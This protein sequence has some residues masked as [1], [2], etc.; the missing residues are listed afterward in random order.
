MRVDKLTNKLMNKLMN[1]FNDTYKKMIDLETILRQTFISGDIIGQGATGTIG[2]VDIEGDTYVYKRAPFK[3]GA[4]NPEMEREILVMQMIELPNNE[5]IHTPI[6]IDSGDIE[7]EGIMY[8]FILMSL[9]KD[10]KT[11]KDLKVKDFMILLDDVFEQ[12]NRIQETGVTSHNDLHT[13]NVLAVVRRPGRKHDLT[14][15]RSILTGMKA[16]VIDFGRASIKSNGVR[17]TSPCTDLVS[18]IMGYTISNTDYLLNARYGNIINDPGNEM[19][20]FYNSEGYIQDDN[21]NR[22]MI[23]CDIILERCLGISSNNI[24]S[25]YDNLRVW[26]FKRRGRNKMSST[27]P[28]LFFFTNRHIQ[29]IDDMSLL[30]SDESIANCRKALYDMYHS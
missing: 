14:D 21:Y 3:E 27:L 17:T 10:I 1:K 8:T 7:Y 2:R 11:V 29:F 22:L 26:N 6:Y 28:A 16:V 15:F 18:F 30:R 13:S 4:R 23:L 9:V 12:L 20:N 25:F 24:P 19:R 5:L